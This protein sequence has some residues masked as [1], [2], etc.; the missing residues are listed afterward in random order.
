MGAFKTPAPGD[1]RD[2]PRS[3][4]AVQSQDIDFWKE[5]CDE[6][7]DVIKRLIGRHKELQRHHKE[8]GEELE[9]LRL[10]NNAQYWM[11]R[12]N[13]VSRDNETL[14]AANEELRTSNIKLTEMVRKWH[15][16]YKGHES[17]AAERE[18]KNGS[19]DGKE[20]VSATK[21]TSKIRVSKGSTSLKRTVDNTDSSAPESSTKRSQVQL[22]T[23]IAP[24]TLVSE[25][26]SADSVDLNSIFRTWF[27]NVGFR[28][29]Y[30]VWIIELLSLISRRPLSQLR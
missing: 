19:K 10:A 22:T 15:I 3:P 29:S 13:R 1:D 16:K 6:K 24:S 5:L 17:R 2:S 4:P 18:E 7:D 25:T 20:E 8:R 26:A 9:N 23:D 12:Y 30:S 14:S 11:Q 21:G 27:R 28:V